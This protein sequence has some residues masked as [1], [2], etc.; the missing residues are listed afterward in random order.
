MHDSDISFSLVQITDM[1]I[2]L[3]SHSLMMSFVICSLFFQFLQSYT[4]FYTNIVAKKSTFSCICCLRSSCV[5]RT[6]KRRGVQKK[7]K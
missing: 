5:E 1:C 2:S 6:E 4:F 3:Y 7:K